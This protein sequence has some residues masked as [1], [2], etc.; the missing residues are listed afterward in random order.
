MYTCY[1]EV[2][3][4]RSS[5]WW[6]TKHETLTPETIFKA[7]KIQGFFLLLLLHVNKVNTSCLVLRITIKIINHALV[8]RSGY[9][10]GKN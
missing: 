9:C 8:A 6:A 7:T 10:R 3:G 5:G 1:M 2:V 4:R